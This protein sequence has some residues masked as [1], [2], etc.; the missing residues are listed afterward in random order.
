ME[1]IGW[2]YSR[3]EEGRREG[4]SELSRLRI[5]RGSTRLREEEERVR[6]RRG[7]VANLHWERRRRQRGKRESVRYEGMTQEKEGGWVNGGGRGVV[8]EREI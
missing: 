5:E 1:R 3:K 7:Y 2:V 8:R 4:K 6:G